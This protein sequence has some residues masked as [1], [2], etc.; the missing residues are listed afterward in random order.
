MAHRKV[1]MNKFASLTSLSF[2]F[3]RHKHRP[4][5][6]KT[7]LIKFWWKSEIHI[8]SRYYHKYDPTQ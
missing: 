4:T 6:L 3:L 5:N 8:I 1:F 2:D 7:N